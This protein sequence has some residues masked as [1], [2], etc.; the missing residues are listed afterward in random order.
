MANE[1]NNVLDRAK[2]DMTAN[3]QLSRGTYFDICELAANGLEF[4]L[5]MSIRD[6][7]KLRAWINR[8]GM[9]KVMR[10]QVQESGTMR[11][12]FNLQ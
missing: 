8:H 3:G 4:C 12:C 5:E 11:V 7:Y 6:A 1:I 9:K 10:Q 2:A